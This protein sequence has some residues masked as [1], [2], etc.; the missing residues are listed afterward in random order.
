LA[1][2]PKQPKTPK[3]HFLPVYELMSDS[4]ANFFLRIGDFETSVF[5][6]RLF[7]TFFFKKNFFLNNFYENPS[8][9]LGYQGWVKILMITLI[10]SQKSP[11]PKT[12]QPPVYNLLQN[13]RH[14]KIFIDHFSSSIFGQKLYFWVQI[15]F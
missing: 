12:F 14:C 13:Y 9:G 3:I 7:W 2:A 11:N 8:N 1:Y 6:S 5:L 10:S 15:P 4:L